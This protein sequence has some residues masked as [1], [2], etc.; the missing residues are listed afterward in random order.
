MKKSNNA[1]IEIDV[2]FDMKEI[3]AVKKRKTMKSVDILSL[4]GGFL[5]L[6]AGFSF[7]S[8]GELI[9]HFVVN[10]IVKIASIRSGKIHAMQ[11]KTEPKLEKQIWSFLAKTIG[12]FFEISSI[13]S[14]NRVGNNN[15]KF[16][17]RSIWLISCIISMILSYFMIQEAFSK[18][19]VN[20]IYMSL[21]GQETRIEDVSKLIF[22]FK[23]AIFKNKYF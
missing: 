5:G 14:L 19:Q 9:L 2:E 22:Y 16:I 1:E 6:F 17:E 23:V 20:K 13:H 15:N 4:I 18:L 8:A 12:R 7:L 21:E 10:P 3:F 11:N